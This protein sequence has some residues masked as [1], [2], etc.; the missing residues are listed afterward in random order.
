LNHLLGSLPP[1]Q[2]G[3]NADFRLLKSCNENYNIKVTTNPAYNCPPQQ[4]QKEQKVS[5]KSSNWW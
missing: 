2:H 3:H 5:L 4:T 1:F